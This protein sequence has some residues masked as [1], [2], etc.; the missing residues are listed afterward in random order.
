MEAQAGAQAGHQQGDTNPEQE[1]AVPILEG[2]LSQGLQPWALPVH[3]RAWGHSGH[4]DWCHIF[5]TGGCQVDLFLCKRN[6]ARIP[7]KLSLLHA[8]LY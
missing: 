4:S 3:G 2:T 1:A 6:T 8:G 7:C 5:G